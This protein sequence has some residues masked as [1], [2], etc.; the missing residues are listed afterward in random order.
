MPDDGRL[1]LGGTGWKVWRGFVLRSTA[2]PLAELTAAVGAERAATGPPSPR[3]L[4]PAV[5]LARTDTFTRALLW[6]NPRAVDEVVGSLLR[7]TTG[8]SS[9]AGATG[10]AARR[11]ERGRRFKTRM[12]GQYLQRYYTRNE[13]VGFFGPVA[14]GTFQD[15]PLMTLKA[16]PGLTDERHV[17]FE[18]W[19]V[20][21]L[22]LRLSRPLEIRRGLPPALAVGVSR[23]GRSLLRAGER[24]RR[25]TRPEATLT[26]LVDG[27]RTA[28]D[29]G[30][31]LGDEAAA[32]GMLQA[33]EDEGYVNWTFDIPLDLRPE[34]ALREQLEALERTP[35]AA[36]ALA[37]LARLTD[38]R[39]AV[40]RAETADALARTLAEAGR[41]YSE[42][43]G[44][45]ADRPRQD[46]GKGFGLLVSAERR[47]VDLTVG[48]AL[49]DDLAPA[50]GLLLDS[51]RWFC[52]RIGEEVTDWL[53][54]A[55]HELA[56]LYGM[57]DVPLD[58]LIGRV[59]ARLWDAASCAHVRDELV[60]R[61]EAVLAPD[62]AAR[63]VVHT[64]AGLA[65][66]VA[67]TF[68]SP[69]PAWYGG[70]QH[71]PDVMIAA[72]SVEAVNRGDYQAVMGELH[73]GMTTFDCDSM[74]CCAADPDAMVRRPAEAA[75]AGG[76]PRI[77]P[78]HPRTAGGPTGFDYPP[79]DTGSPRYTY[80][81]LGERA[82][83][84]RVPSQPVAAS[85]VRVARTADG[86]V[87]RFPDG[88]VLPLLTVVGEFLVYQTGTGFGVLPARP[89]TPRVTV[90]RLVIARECWRIPV[91]EF[92]P[93]PD[94]T[95][96]EVY[97]RVRAVAAERG[98]PRHCFWRATR[99][100]KPLYL[101]LHSPLL[102]HVLV[103]TLAEGRP[104]RTVAFTEMLPAP[105]EL[106]LPDEED[107]R[108]TSELRIT[109]SDG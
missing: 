103:H 3:T 102:V 67:E 71:S 73:A 61:W 106:W 19:A 74:L 18:D 34:Q 101:D 27:R 89:H 23:M 39:D 2:L 91:E 46:A 77:V 13:S 83:A 82:G 41:R 37:D 44:R 97:E 42:L 70:R 98:L 81:S 96:E 69:A 8:E 85:S 45:P 25:L 43:T 10:R 66:A 53:T 50:L 93:R 4:A 30:R 51:A 65:A 76:P 84:R 104:E 62:P 75:L 36:T 57:D 59:D 63:R 49:L 52:R 11:A 80:L 100:Q 78:L 109:V 60:A 86:L 29:I 94:M 92:L 33:L 54:T 55:H 1:P 72:E 31:A 105:D 12:L 40:A 108:Y 7:H 15:G 14:W 20:H 16:G 21:E 26:G 6:Q 88:T 47:A 5:E 68:A 64:S 90:D 107:R 99:G 32:L 38:A 58:A 22:G 17:L 48:T 35:A 95:Q 87:A 28:A 9:S 79:P 56:A 24:P